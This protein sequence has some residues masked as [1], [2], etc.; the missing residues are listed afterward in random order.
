MISKKLRK[1]C[2]SKIDP[3]IINVFEIAIKNITNFHNK[4]LPENYEI[5]EDNVKK[6]IVWKPIESVGLYV[7]GG[8]AVYPSS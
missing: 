1:D 5:D 7:P 4:Q 6:G 8:K 2:K 3:K